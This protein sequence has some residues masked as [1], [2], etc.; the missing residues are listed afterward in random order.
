VNKKRKGCETI[1]IYTYMYIY[2]WGLGGS[3]ARGDSGR[4]REPLST[5]REGRREQTGQKAV[6][7]EQ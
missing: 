2:I 1:Y 6:I 3:V 7:R 4:S 5:N